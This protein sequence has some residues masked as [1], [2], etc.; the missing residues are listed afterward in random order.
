MAQV[1]FVMGSSLAVPNTTTASGPVG[2]SH[3]SHEQLR[4]SY[5]TGNQGDSHSQKNTY[6][7]VHML[8]SQIGLCLALCSGQMACLYKCA[9]LRKDGM[10][11]ET[12][13][14]AVE[15]MKLP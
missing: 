7:C 1:H 8:M 9:M 5:H 3:G 10:E 14:R 4:Y 2:C 13:R 6:G 11:V 15:S 12:C